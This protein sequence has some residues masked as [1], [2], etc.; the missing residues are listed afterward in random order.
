VQ[1]ALGLSAWSSYSFPVTSPDVPSNPVAPSCDG[2][3]AIITD[4][5][6][7]P[8]TALNVQAAAG[9]API[10]NDNGLTLQVVVIEVWSL[11]KTAKVAG[12]TQYINITGPSTQVALTCDGL[13]PGTNYTARSRAR[14]VLGWS[15]LTATQQCDQ[16]KVGTETVEQCLAR[17][18]CSCSGAPPCCETG[19]SF[20]AGATSGCATDP[21]PKPPLDLTLY[22]IIGAVLGFFL[23]CAIAT[24]YACYKYNLTKIFA[25]KLRRKREAEPKVEDFMSS[26]FMPMEDE[27]PELFVNPVLAAKMQMKKDRENQGKRKGG[28]GTGRSGGLRRLNLGTFGVDGTAPKKKTAG[29]MRGEVLGFLGAEE[30]PKKTVRE[31]ALE[32]GV[33][34]ARFNRRMKDL[35]QGGTVGGCGAGA[36]ETSGVQMQRKV[37]PARKPRAPGWVVAQRPQYPARAPPIPTPALPRRLCRRA[38]ASARGMSAVP[39]PCPKSSDH[40]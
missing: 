35:R 28:T 19:W 16:Q 14:N 38:G 1:T 12:C 11:D 36:A 20:W 40:A 5:G 2:S 17:V 37:W 25:P 4:A 18:G 8:D 22:Y 10:A 6:G 31:V 7:A 15:N 33:S 27:D 29:E 21:T 3:S 26:D 9:G 13:S 24:V 39:R 32:K 23:L 34:D 30:G